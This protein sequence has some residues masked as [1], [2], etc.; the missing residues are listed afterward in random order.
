[1]SQRRSVSRYSRTHSSTLFPFYPLLLSFSFPLIYMKDPTKAGGGERERKVE[2]WT[3]AFSRRPTN[4][5]IVRFVVNKMPLR[6]NN[7][8]RKQKF[9][10][11]FGSKAR[12]PHK[13]INL[14]ALMDWQVPHKT[15]AIKVVFF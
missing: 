2:C 12:I 13:S 4:L 7:L 9:I 5:S 15:G 3:R 1:M 6:C 8:N 11:S 10:L 14:S